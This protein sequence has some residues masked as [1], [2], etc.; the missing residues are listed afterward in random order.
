MQAD[1]FTLPLLYHLNEQFGSIHKQVFF[2]LNNDGLFINHENLSP[3]TQVIELKKLA[4]LNAL[5][6]IIRFI[7]KSHQANAV[8]MHGNALLFY[9]FLI[10]FLV[11]KTFWIIYGGADMNLW[12]THG[13][14][15][16]K[17]KLLNKIKT[18]TL[19]RIYGHITYIKGDSDWVNQSY[20]SKAIHFHSPVYL[21]NVV[22]NSHFDCQSKQSDILT[23]LVGNSCSPSNNHMQVFNWLKPYCDRIKII[24]PLSYGDYPD[25]KQEIVKEGNKLFGDQFIPITEF[26]SLDKYKKF[27]SGIDIAI[28]NH[29]RQEAMGVTLTLLGLGKTVYVN[30]NT[31]SFNMFQD[32]GFRVFSNQDLI[33]SNSLMENKDTSYNKQLLE[34]Y[35]S[36]NYLNKSWQVIYNAA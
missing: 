11:K 35:N 31:T 23:V 36:I 3:L 15:D 16:L 34:K 22:D 17:N 29:Y 18:V 10:Q 14:F 19:K 4:G 24:C 13:S 7:S 33:H 30:S 27:L 21:S 2:V 12:Q 6:N 26:M 25:Y 28:F 20:G 9:L 32:L 8:I 1:K 5:Y